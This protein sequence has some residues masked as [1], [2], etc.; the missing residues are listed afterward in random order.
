MNETKLNWQDLQL[1]LSVARAHGLAGASHSTGKSAPTL[2]RRMLALESTTGRELFH[3]HSHG[4]ELT[5]EGHDLLKTAERL[6]SLISPLDRAAHNNGRKIVKVSAGTWMTRS[7]CQHLPDI[8]GED[9]SL[10]LRFIAAEQRLDI[11]HRETIIGIRNQ[12]P[13]DPALAI[14]RTGKVR[15]AGYA[16]DEAVEPWIRVHTPTP[17]SKW[18]LEQS[19]EPA[20]VEVT[21]PANAL[22]L[23]LSG[24]G[25]VLLPTFVGENIAE[26]TRVTAHIS[27]LSH[28]QWLVVHQDDRHQPD[29]RSVIDRIFRVAQQLHRPSSSKTT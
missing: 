2:G 23:A 10:R 18:L 3:R 5:R 25:R 12:R 15:F 17:S 8:M 26:L 27:A 19:L 20:P 9:E 11:H 21:S 29:V 4:Y 1:F 14:R 28:D 24:I 13:D 16:A 22:D 7:L 6:E